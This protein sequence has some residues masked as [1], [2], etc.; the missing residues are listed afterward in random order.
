VLRYGETPVI[1]LSYCDLIPHDFFATDKTPGTAPMNMDMVI[2][3][4]KRLKA[5][6]NLGLCHCIGATNTKTSRCK[7]SATEPAA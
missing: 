3:D 1:F 7:A 5:R 4:V 2:E 6:D